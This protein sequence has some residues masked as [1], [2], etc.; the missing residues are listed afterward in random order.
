MRYALAAVLTA[1]TVVTAQDTGT[2]RYVSKDGGYSVTFP[3][4]VEYKTKTL[5]VPGG[6]KMT[7]VG[8]DKA[9]DKKALVVMHLTMPPGV[10]QAMPADKMLEMIGKQSA[11]KAGGTE[12]SNKEFTFGKQKYPGREIVL[13]KDGALVQIKVIAADPNLYVLTVGGTKDYVEGAE[14]KDFLKSFELTGGGG[15]GPKGSPATKSAP[16]TKKAVI[17]D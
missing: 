14:V 16:A 2:G 3:K 13:D 15:A 7:L 17:K 11:A 1:A 9:A 6:M 8:T 10:F 12:V 4:G 5:D